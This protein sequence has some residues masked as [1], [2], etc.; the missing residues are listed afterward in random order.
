MDLKLL[1][2]RNHTCSYL[3]PL[4]S[5]SVQVHTWLG[6]IN[7]FVEEDENEFSYSIRLSALDLLLCLSEEKA[8]AGPLY[9]AVVSAIERHLQEVRQNQAAIGENWWKI[10]EACALAVSCVVDAARSQQAEF[11]CETFARGV[12]MPDLAAG[13]ESLGC[14][15]ELMYTL[16]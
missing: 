12:L 16:T 7:Q 6:D 14:R 2:T 3:R 5:H 13:G 8:L 4:L 15:W 1:G 11:D 10:H 9:S